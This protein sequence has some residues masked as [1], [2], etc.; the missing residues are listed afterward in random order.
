M[1]FCDTRSAWN[2][3][4]LESWGSALY[5]VS[6]RPYTENLLLYKYDN[7]KHQTLISCF[8]GANYTNVA[9]ALFPEVSYWTVFS[10]SK[11]WLIFLGWLLNITICA[12]KDTNTLISTLFQGELCIQK[13]FDH[14]Q[15]F[16]DN[17]CIH[18]EEKVLSGTILR[19]EAWQNKLHL[20]ADH[21]ESVF[22]SVILLLSCT[23]HG[24]AI[25]DWVKIS[26]K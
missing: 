17:P 26:V 13:L 10:D 20:F 15:I 22:R 9:T 18:F 5:T 7:K 14:C 12:M 16:M 25:L 24:L 2:C 4:T 8:L 11:K 19:H 21:P 1:I 6:N 23:L 3:R